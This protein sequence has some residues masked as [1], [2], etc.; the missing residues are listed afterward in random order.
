MALQAA[1]SETRRDCGGP[2]RAVV[3][4][5]DHIDGLRRACCE[6]QCVET[7]DEDGLFI[8]GRHKDQQLR[9]VSGGMR[10]LRRADETQGVG[11]RGK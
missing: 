3:G 2:I 1:D 4:N 11:D 7:F 6:S 10:R 8:V 5:D 9:N